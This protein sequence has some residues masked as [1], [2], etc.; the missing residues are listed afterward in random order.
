M[1]G[2][3][4]GRLLI[5]PVWSL[6]N[7][8]AVLWANGRST[9]QTPLERVRKTRTIFNPSSTTADRWRRRSW[10]VLAKE[11]FQTIRHFTRGDFIATADSGWTAA[12]TEASRVAISSSSS[13]SK[14]NF[15]NYKPNSKSLSQ[16]SGRSETRFLIRDAC[17]G[18]L[19]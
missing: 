10:V 18:R 5:L 3:L 16:N 4:L 9:T 11:L 13:T 17:E 19:T 2:N 1:S 15:Q 8:Q 12:A 14:A 6:A 7:L